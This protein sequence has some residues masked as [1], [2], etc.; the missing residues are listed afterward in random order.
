MIVIMIMIININ[1]LIINIVILIIMK[2]LVPP[3][4]A[5]MTNDPDP[6]D[7]LA[8]RAVYLPPPA[9][10]LFFIHCTAQYTILYCALYSRYIS[11]HIAQKI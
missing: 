8:A 9:R 3:L 6:G 1:I 4:E 2:M 7:W 5:S 11:L 10:L